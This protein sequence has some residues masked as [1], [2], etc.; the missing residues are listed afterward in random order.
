MA[1]GGEKTIAQNRRATHDYAIEDRV[2]AIDGR[3]GSLDAEIAA[4][5]ERLTNAQLKLTELTEELQRI[6]RRLDRRYGL[7]ERRAVAAYKA[8]PAAAA[9]GLL[10]ATS[11][12]DLVDRLEYFQ[13]GLDAEAELIA[14][15]ESLESE[16]E[17]AR[18]R[19]ERKKE[20]IADE[21]LAL[22]ERRADVAEVLEE[23]AA[24]LAEKEDVISATRTLL[25]SAEDREARLEEWLDQ[26]ESDSARLESILAA[27]SGGAPAGGPLP[28][29]GGELLWPTSGALTSPYGYRVHPIFGDT[30]LHSGID[31]GAAYG[32]PVFAADEGTVSY[33]GE[34]SGYG[35]V[36]AIDHGGGFATTYNHLS[37]YSVGSGESIER[38]ETIASVG[39]TGYCTGPHL[40][41]EVR[42]NGS[43]VDPLPYLQ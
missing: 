2:D 38:G 26:L 1:A 40:H 7:L 43:P 15:I 11:F 16:T 32:A 23:R 22:E 20:M 39:C 13:A 25:A 5:K 34:M 12:A 28:S 18:D 17:T 36:V 24:A 37:G 19:V 42:I 3:L 29:R 14:E 4:V 27:D 21:Q 33:V 35:N 8:G 9:D 6:G 31:I 41:F 10:A 30:R